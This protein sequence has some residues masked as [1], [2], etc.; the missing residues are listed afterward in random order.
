M[1]YVDMDVHKTMCQATV[2]DEDGELLDQIRF[3]NLTWNRPGPLVSQTFSIGAV[4]RRAIHYFHC[5]VSVK[6]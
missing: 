1:K 4:V 2:L 5:M 3:A 6:R